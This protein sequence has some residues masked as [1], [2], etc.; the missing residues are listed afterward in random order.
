MPNVSAACEQYRAKARRSCL[1]YNGCRVCQDALKTRAQPG[2]LSLC[3]N[4]QHIDLDTDA[5][6]LEGAQAW[7]FHY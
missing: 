5:A 4:L 6:L 3:T 1:A 7:L 2:R